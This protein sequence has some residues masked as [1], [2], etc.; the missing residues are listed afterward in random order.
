MD[1]LLNASGGLAAMDL[2][3][4]VSAKPSSGQIRYVPDT[5]IKQAYF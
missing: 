1:R 4:A 2:A 3:E 5:L